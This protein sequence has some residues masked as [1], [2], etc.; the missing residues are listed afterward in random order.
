L[1]RARASS[2]RRIVWA[3]V[4]GRLELIGADEEIR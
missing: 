2:L 1:S 3:D 4:D